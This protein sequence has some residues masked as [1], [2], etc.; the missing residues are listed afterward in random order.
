M[1]ALDFA[2][3][4]RNIFQWLAIKLGQAITSSG[5]SQK[6]EWGVGDVS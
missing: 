2:T 4:I 6:G 5:R 1:V 3:L